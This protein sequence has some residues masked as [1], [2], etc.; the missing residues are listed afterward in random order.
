L[1]TDVS[2]AKSVLPP[3]PGISLNTNAVNRDSNE[4]LQQY[5]QLRW[6]L[7][8]LQLSVAALTS[9]WAMPP[10]SMLRPQ[11]PNPNCEPMLPTHSTPSTFT[12]QLPATLTTDCKPW[13]SRHTCATWH[14]NP[15]SCQQHSPVTGPCLRSPCG[16]PAGQAP[17][18]SPSCHTYRHRKYV[19]QHTVGI[20]LQLHCICS[21]V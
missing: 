20:E 7:C 8:S 11:N 3:Y 15:A 9:D 13:A 4:S 6:P 2:T 1:T 10:F 18:R 17:S 16:A 19:E 5:G 21:L 12:L 14:L